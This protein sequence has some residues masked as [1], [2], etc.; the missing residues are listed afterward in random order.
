MWDIYFKIY[1]AFFKM[2]F[3]VNRSI[4]EENRPYWNNNTYIFEIS[5]NEH[6]LKEPCSV[7]KVI[8]PLDYIPIK[9]II[10]KKNF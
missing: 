7:S 10:Q 4:T 6:L 8:K 1:Y 5:I 3:L 2:Q 9:R